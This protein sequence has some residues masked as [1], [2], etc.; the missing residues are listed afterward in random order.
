MQLGCAS[1]LKILFWHTVF[2]MVLPKPYRFVKTLLNEV[3]MML[4]GEVL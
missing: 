3:M 1:S 4:K 2:K